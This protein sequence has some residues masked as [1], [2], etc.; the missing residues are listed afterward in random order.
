MKYLEQLVRPLMG[1]G[2]LKSVRGKGGGYML[3]KP[4][5]EIRAG[6]ILRV[7]EGSTGAVACEGLDGSCG[8]AGLC[9][10][11]KFWTG[12][13]AAI[14]AYVDGVTLAE[15]SAVPEVH[16][17]VDLSSLRR[18]QR[19]SSEISIPID[20]GFVDNKTPAPFAVG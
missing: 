14:D 12:L 16:L 9:S 2:L 18:V 19:A 15:L 13:E 6:D 5:E 11:V 8:R 20:P 1:A 7:A 17:E 3:A 4:A 10:T